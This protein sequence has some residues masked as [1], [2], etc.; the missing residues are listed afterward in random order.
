M[1]RFSRVYIEISNI[2]NLQCDFCPEVERGNKI[3]SMDV[4]Q[5]LLSQVKPL[6]EEV[7]FHLMGEPTTHPQFSQFAEQAYAMGVPVNLT[8][9]GT[10]LNMRNNAEV[11]LSPAFRQVNFSLQSYLSNF[12]GGHVLDYLQPIFDWTRRA[13]LERPDLYINYRL[14]NDGTAQDV[15]EREVFLSPIEKEFAVTI[16]RKIDVA[17]NKSKNVLGRLYLHFDSRFQWPHMSTATPQTSGTCYGLQS[18][19]AIQA[20]GTVVPCCLDKEAQL[21][22]GKVGP[23]ASSI[24]EVLNSPRALKIQKGF[25]N[26]QLVENLCQKCSFIRRFDRKD[27]GSVVSTPYAKNRTFPESS[28]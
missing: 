12:K 19:F 10:L 18:H 27:R 3:M 4:F 21:I 7:T 28:S 14:W 16:S 22:L 15:L 13:L 9:N 24:L 26:F 6:T 5:E 25:E 1:K 11:L 8:T 20:D 17:H 2:C 23:N